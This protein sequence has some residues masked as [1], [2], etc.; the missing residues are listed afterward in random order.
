M[1]TRKGS[2]D[3]ATPS[4]NQQEEWRKIVNDVDFW[5]QKDGIDEALPRFPEIVAR[6]AKGEFHSLTSSVQQG[7]ML[8]GNTGCGKTKRIKFL[9][10]RLGLHLIESHEL[11]A[12]IAKN[13]DLE[14]F[15]EITRTD[16][17]CGFQT[18]KRYYDLIIDDLG[19]EDTES[20][21]Y[22]NRRDIMAK[23]ITQR[24]LAYMEFGDITHFTTNLNSESIARRYGDRILSR[25]TEMCVFVS[26]PGGDRRMAGRMANG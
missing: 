18:P 5:R 24:H 20:M 4:E 16:R 6:I 14:F 1:L 26:M 8:L 15:R 7:L 12:R 17:K 21:T 22:G 11:V 19:A 23:V 3:Q 25:L 10:R 9:E 13:D 2:S